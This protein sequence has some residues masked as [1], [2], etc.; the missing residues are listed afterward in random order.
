MFALHG[1]AL[2]A[3]DQSEL[4]ELLESARRGA[5]IV[6]HHDSITGTMCVAEEGCAGTDQV[7]G[8]HNV[9]QDYEGVFFVEIAPWR[10]TAATPLAL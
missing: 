4:W 8:A 10:A 3:D 1:D 2:G 5:G 9:L 6:Q 7:V